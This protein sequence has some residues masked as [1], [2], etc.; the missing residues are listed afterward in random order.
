MND[1]YKG[2]FADSV[3]EAIIVVA[4]GVLAGVLILIGVL[5]K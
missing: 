1:Y 2:R 4:C 5:C 3:H